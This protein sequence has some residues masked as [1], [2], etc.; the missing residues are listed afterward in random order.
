[1]DVHPLLFEPIFKPKMWGGRRLAT[2]VDKSLPGN[3]PIGESWELVDLEDEWSVVRSGSAAGHSISQLVAAWGE[4][5]LGRVELCDGRFPLLIK[6][7]DATQTL[8]VQV[9][10]DEAMAAKLGANVR[11]KHEA[12]YIVDAEPGGFIYRGLNPGVDRAAFESAVAQ[13]RV[14]ECLHRIEVRKGQCYYLPSGTV[15]ALGAGVVVAEIQTPSDITYRVYDFGRVDPSTGREREL[16][17]DQALECIDFSGAPIPGEERSHVAS[18]WTA[19]TRLVTCDS[20]Q[21]ER[22][23]MVEELDMPI[24]YGGMVVWVVLEGDG[25]IEMPK[26]AS[27]GVTRFSRGDVVLLPAGLHDASLHTDTQCLWLEVTVPETS[28]LADFARVDPAEMKA[29][30]TPLVQLRQPAS[31][32]PTSAP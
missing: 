14:E 3:Q 12:W 31:D 4:D 21:I 19:V 11:L 20:F 1:M 16:H 22:V 10:P 23:R 13:G 7:L 29:P 24:P 32:G 18:V 6:F 15:H 30:T 28:D 9:H 27:D 5:L 8:S 17:L 25:Q 2:L 26:S